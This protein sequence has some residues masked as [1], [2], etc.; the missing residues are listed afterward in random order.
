MD[1]RARLGLLA[2]AV[3]TAA[4]GRMVG[5]LREIDVD[6][7]TDAPIVIDVK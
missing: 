6:G 3:A 1:R 2:V 5:R 7:K 4:L